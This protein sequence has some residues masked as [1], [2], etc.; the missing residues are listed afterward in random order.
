MN[1]LAFTLNVTFAPHWG[2]PLSLTEKPQ[3]R[4]TDPLWADIYKMT[5]TNSALASQNLQDRAWSPIS[6]SSA[7]IKMSKISI[8]FCISKLY[9]FVSQRID[10]S[11][12][13]FRDLLFS[14]CSLPI[15][16]SGTN[17]LMKFYLDFFFS[18][19]SWKDR[20]KFLV[21]ENPRRNLFR[22]LFFKFN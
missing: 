7:K 22:T 15:G 8:R 19:F 18:F 9:K 11:V 14:I 17:Y 2:K 16:S 3:I 21:G 12:Q 1:V 20:R 5:S 13:S 6:P 4:G 10:R